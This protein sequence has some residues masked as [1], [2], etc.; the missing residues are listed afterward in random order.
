MHQPLDVMDQRAKFVPKGLKAEFV[1]EAQTNREA[2]RMVK[3]GEIQL[4]F[5]S[6][7]N[8]VWSDQF[9]RMLFSEVYVSNLV[10]IVVDEAHCIKTWGDRFRVAFA[11]I[12]M[13]RSVTSSH[14]CIMALTA[15]ATRD[16]LE[17]VTERL[18]ME[19]PRV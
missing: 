17:I 5:I 3:K 9:R 1:G 4:V 2:E 16:T 6:P 8:I 7:E 18:A 13:L 14:V 11:Q 10:A 19:D 15:T 12:G